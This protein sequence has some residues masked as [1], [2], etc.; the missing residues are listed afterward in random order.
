[1]FRKSKNKSTF[2]RVLFSSNSLDK[3]Y[4][5]FLLS[6]HT[7][8]I[9]NKEKLLSTVRCQQ[10]LKAIWQR[11]SLSDLQ[12]K[13]LYLKPIERYAEL[14][15]QFPA[16][17]SHHHAYLGGMLEHGLEIVAYALKF[18][19]SYLLPIGVSSEERSAQEDIWTAG[20]A[21]VALIH[22]I[23]KLAVDIHVE[24]VDGSIWHPWHGSLKKT[25]DLNTVKTVNI[26][27]TV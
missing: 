9:S 16:S 5:F 7:L 6:L 15:Q 25:T 8:V 18:R 19:Q 22:D 17:E 4:N 24:Y 26:V 10:L 1:L 2:N 20:I 21:Y 3:L 12:F 11:T 27:Y 13:Q 23:G 14:V